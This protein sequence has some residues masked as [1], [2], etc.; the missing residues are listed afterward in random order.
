MKAGIYEANF[1]FHSSPK[2]HSQL[3]F[4]VASMTHLQHSSKTIQTITHSNI[5][6]FPKDAVTMF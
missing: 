4:S 2:I 3:I 6:G 5:D 1:L